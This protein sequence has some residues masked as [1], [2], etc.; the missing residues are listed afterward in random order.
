LERV[1]VSWV[2]HNP[3]RIGY[4]QSMNFVAAMI[5][6]VCKGNE[7][8]ALTIFTCLMEDTTFGDYFHRETN[9]EALHNDTRN[10]ETKLVQRDEQLANHM[11]SLGFELASV[12]PTWLLTCFFLP[13]GPGRALGVL[14]DVM[15]CGNGARECLIE[16]ALDVLIQHR[17]EIMVCEDID[18]IY[19]V[20]K[21]PVPRNDS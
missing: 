8:E 16:N 18:E 21:R 10:L 11:Y 7:D 3:I 14:D 1:L 13:V 5:L 2:A 17:N 15:R 9:F 19:R 4:C 12:T 20:L 6:A